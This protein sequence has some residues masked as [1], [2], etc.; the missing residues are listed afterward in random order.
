MKF[1]ARWLKIIG[2]LVVVLA[3]GYFAAWA[4]YWPAFGPVSGIQEPLYYN[5]SYI[6]PMAWTLRQAAPG[7]PAPAPLTLY[8]GDS[9][10]QSFFAAADHLAALRIWL[11]GA[12]GGEVVRVSF[13]SL[14]SVPH[15]PAADVRYTATLRLDPSGRGRYYNLRISPVAQAEGREFQ[16]DVQAV[17]GTILARVGYVDPLP[18][19]LY[20]NEYPSPG[21]LDLGV[22]HHAPPGLWTLRLAGRRLLPL[23][24]RARVRQYKPAAF[25]G[26]VFG[27][28]CLACALGVGGVLWALAPVVARPRVT[29]SREPDLSSSSFRES[30]TRGEHDKPLAR[31]R[32]RWVWK[33]TLRKAG[34]ALVG[35]LG[36]VLIAARWRPAGMLLFGPKIVLAGEEAAVAVDSVGSVAGDARQTSDLVTRLA[37]VSRLPEPRHVHARVERLDG[38]Q[39]ACI[40]VPA[41]SS[42]AYGLRVPR[43]GELRLG[44]ALPEGAT[45]ALVFQVQVQGHTLL[46]QVLGPDQAGAWHDAVLDLRPYG[47]ASPAGG[48][49]AHLTL[50]VRPA[51]LPAAIAAE[52]AGQPAA[53][54][55]PVAA[56]WAA[57]HLTSARSWLLP[58]PLPEPPSYVLEAGFVEP[59]SAPSPAEIELLGAD[60]ELLP[61]QGTHGALR[62]T[63]YWRARRRLY[64]PYTVFVHLLDAQGEIRGQ[65]DSEPL[66]GTYPTDV[67]PVDGI[68][69][70]TIIRD[71]YLVPADG[72]L[73]PGARLAVGLYEVTTRTRLAAYD[74]NGTRLPEDQ[75]LVQI[76]DG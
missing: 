47:G 37:F 6:W 15:V 61:E 46:E 52:E 48:A 36:I 34:W 35:L 30:L 13:R 57:P 58:E 63:L 51:D 56:L 32:G 62:V 1:D 19:R 11:A 55:L 4:L 69:G 66:S 65:W 3:A 74:V 71:S 67:W 28:L 10:H 50:S 14:E 31:S 16:L 22:Y 26:P 59:G 49:L 7:V 54:L 29:D 76:D 5:D 72:P 39:R 43:D 2:V 25:K 27:L 17:E 40:A 73:P 12:R 64:V 60:V 9:A 70:R 24:V 21:D 44:F 42:I 20:L 18:G 68:D 38:E 53:G 41:L 33:P 8:P 23:A 75:V 45:Q